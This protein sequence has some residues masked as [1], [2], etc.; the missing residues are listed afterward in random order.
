[1][2][3]YMIPSL[4]IA[5]SGVIGHQDQ[6]FFTFEQSD[7]GAE[8]HLYA[9]EKA[10]KPISRYL[11]GKFGSANNGLSEFSV[12]G[13]RMS[14]LGAKCPECSCINPRSLGQW[15]KGVDDLEEIEETYICE[16]CQI[17]FKRVGKVTWDIPWVTERV[18][19]SVKPQSTAFTFENTGDITIEN[20]S[21]EGYDV[22]VKT[23]EAGDINIKNIRLSTKPRGENNA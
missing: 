15:W 4:M 6:E 5:I 22:G 21:L 10:E 12:K 14:R 3:L 16:E 19:S 23:K 18:H 11:Y 1:M 17:V 8:V 2:S 20:A 7:T 13:D 9:N